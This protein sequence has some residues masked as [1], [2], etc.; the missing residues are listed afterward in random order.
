[1]TWAKGQAIDLAQWPALK[2]WFDKVGARP[3]VQDT[4]QAERN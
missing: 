3:A 1:L 4:L 2:T